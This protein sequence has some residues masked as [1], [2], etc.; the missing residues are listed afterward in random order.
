MSLTDSFSSGRAE[1]LAADPAGG[2][3]PRRPPFV[4]HLFE[5]LALVALPGRRGEQAAASSEQDSSMNESGSTLWAGQGCRGQ[6]T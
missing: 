6:D 5:G 3:A 1:H 4:L 2:P